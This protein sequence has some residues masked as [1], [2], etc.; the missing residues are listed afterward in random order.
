MAK[1]QDQENICSSDLLK[2]EVIHAINN[3]MALFLEDFVLRRSE[4]GSS[5]MIENE[6]LEEC[7]KIF[8]QE[9][10]WDEARRRNEMLILHQN[11][12]L[13]ARINNLTME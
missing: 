9:L 1:D 13:N 5:R 12:F 3:E 4:L 6:V 7:S 10:G 11:S 2:C 8:A